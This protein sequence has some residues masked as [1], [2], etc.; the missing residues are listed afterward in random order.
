MNSC[1]FK[2]KL[3]SGT[4]WGYYF[5]AGRDQDGKRIQVFKS[6]FETKGAASTASRVA[7]EEYEKTHGKLTQ[8]RGILGR[9]TWGYVFGEES[10]IGLDSQA[11]AELALQ[12]AVDRRA[13][14]EAIPAEVD[15]TFPE[16]IRYWLTEH[17]ARRCAP[18]TLERY[19]EL[20]EYLI[21]QLGE[22]RLNDLTTAQIQRA[23]H[24][25]EDCGGRVTTE[26][27]D[28]RPLAPKTVR[29]I[30][31]LLYTCL[32]EAD[33]LGVLKIPH[34]MA[35]KR[36]R[37]PRLVKRDPAVLDKEKL[38]ALFTR[39][40]STRLYPV[41][42]LASATG[43]RRGELL[44]LQWPD[45]DESTGELSVSKSLEQLKVGLR[46]KSTKSEKPRRF[47]IPD[48]A[49]S[50][51]A[52]HRA[53]Q[54]KDKRLFGPDYQDHGL[55]FCQPNGAYYSPDRE[56][57]RVKELMR[58]VGIEGVSLHSLRHSFASELL[59]RGV[60]LAVVSERLGHADQNITL[61]IY[62]H[63]MPADTRAAAKVWQD[64]MADVIE[65]SRK[66][67]VKRMLADVCRT[68]TDG[69]VFVEKKRCKV[70]GTTGLEPAT[71][72]VDRPAVR[73]SENLCPPKLRGEQTG[74]SFGKGESDEPCKDRRKAGRGDFR[75]MRAIS[76]S[77][78]SSG[79]V[80]D[81][82]N[83]IW[84][85]GRWRRKTSK[86]VGAEQ[87][88]RASAGRR[89]CGR[90]SRYHLAGCPRDDACASLSAQTG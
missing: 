80:P 57:A 32:A 76:A 2:R 9:V 13:A 77:V 41:V 85:V 84:L 29:H 75:R 53:E 79:G 66:P 17:A 55:I 3:K 35:N 1:V 21:R 60:P 58:A 64:A 44:A 33:R 50:V 71:S 46:V 12:A 6:G 86:V 4:S 34:P 16:Y 42:V 39:A 70:A 10:K 65:D 19:G 88:C 25:L 22:T 43:C 48:W 15:P 18:K 24:R 14:A 78:D 72:D 51:L 67:G 45:L 20:A 69:G 28:G 23:V 68:G 89:S 47:V 7:I 90:S 82:Q 31:T 40:R 61:A 63:A 8:H 54:E 62:S 11:A 5:A 26:Y 37:L 87:C 38:R 59:S 73:N 30:G 27:P 74:S 36:V 81:R 83:D 49:I 56:G 52:D